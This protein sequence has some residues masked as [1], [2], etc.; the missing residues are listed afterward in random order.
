MQ[1]KVHSEVNGCINFSD[2]FEKLKDDGRVLYGA[3]LE[4]AFN[5]QKKLE[6]EKAQKNEKIIARR[7]E[8]D[9]AIEEMTDDIVHLKSHDAVIEFVNIMPSVA[10]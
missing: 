4:A 1:I 9:K 6:L 3:E 8:M 5:R 7:K 2:R 10:F